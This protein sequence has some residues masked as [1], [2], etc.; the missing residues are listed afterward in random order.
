LVAVVCP[1]LWD[2]FAELPITLAVV[3][4]FA[5]V[6]LVV[7]Q[8]WSRST[9]DWSAARRLRF[10]MA[11]LVIAPGIAVALA[12]G[13][14]TIASERNFFGVLRVTR[15]REGVRLVHGTTIHGIQRYGDAAGE[16]TSYYGRRSGV[17]QAIA[18][19]HARSPSLRIGIV[20]LGCG[21][22]ATYGRESD[23]FDMIE[24]NPAVVE[25][26][27]KHFTF[28]SSSRSEIRHHLGDGRLVLER[29]RDAR[30]DLLVLDAFSSDAI[31]A[32]LL[33]REAMTLYQQRLAR[34][35]VIAI[36]VSNNHLDLVPLAH[37]LAADRGLA[38]GAVHSPGDRSIATK[39][40]KWVLI[41]RP[42]NSLWSDE[43]LSGISRPS[44]TALREAPLW[45]DQ[46]HNLASVLKLW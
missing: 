30:F 26:A 23:E 34:D 18:A 33:T 20:G 28:L 46:H 37:R 8:G 4:V 11:A 5:F 12:S 3:A 9:Y 14:E 31:P 22:L 45:T 40:A 17:G 10:G 19:L 1:L 43:R 15:N 6:L 42:A 16:P 2:H 24:I 41:A 25:I 32:H 36:H 39:P 38:S 21:V 44:P 27:R 13:D 7:C 29:M 35:G